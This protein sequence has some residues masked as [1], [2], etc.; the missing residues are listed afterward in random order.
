MRQYIYM[1]GTTPTKVTE[2][3]FSLGGKH[4]FSL[5]NGKAIYL[6]NTAIKKLQPIK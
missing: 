6:S 2:L 4:G 3:G 1:D 5:D